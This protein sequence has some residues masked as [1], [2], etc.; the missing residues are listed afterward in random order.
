MLE[1]GS[2]ERVQCII[3][4]HYM[5]PILSTSLINFLTIY[6]DSSCCMDKCPMKSA[7]LKC[8][9]YYFYLGIRAVDGQ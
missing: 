9:I 4:S 2:M 5:L 8:F 7:L 3:L 1:L 6:C